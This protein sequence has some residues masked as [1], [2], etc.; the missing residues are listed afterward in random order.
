VLP[1]NVSDLTAAPESVLAVIRPFVEKMPVLADGGYE[2]AGHG[3][4]TPVKKPPGMKELDINARTRN[5][6]I[7]AMP[8]RTRLRP[9][10]PALADPP[11]R[12][13]EPRRNRP[14]R[15]ARTRPRAIRAQDAHLKAAENTSMHRDGLIAVFAHV[16]Y[17]RGAASVVKVEYR[18]LSPFRSQ[19][20]GGNPSYTVRATGNDGYLSGQLAHDIPLLSTVMIT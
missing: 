2:G 7:Y 1:G 4:L 10:N 17:N 12:H 13:H 15:P 6:L 19:Q 20:L 9:A 14:D 11:A 5:A 18:N 16:L 3:I 8:R